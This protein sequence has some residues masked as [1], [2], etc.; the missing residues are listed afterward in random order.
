MQMQ[1]A[2]ASDYMS[3]QNNS[4]IGRQMQLLQSQLEY[5]QTEAGK[6]YS[7]WQCQM[8]GRP[9]CSQKAHSA[10]PL[11]AAAEQGYKTATAAAGQIN[12]KLSALRN[13]ESAMT[14]DFISVDDAN[15]GLLARLSALNAAAGHS[16]VLMTMQ[17]LLFLLFAMVECLPVI[18]RT[19]HIFGPQNT[20]EKILR[21]RELDNIR[22]AGGNNMQW[23]KLR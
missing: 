8:Y 23:T 9:F 3:L 13:E 18:F 15:T 19:V 7:Q 22:A 4:G 16:S 10:G 2:D 20:Y 11:A 21:M 5:E 14:Q 17:V 1:Q 12:P 6:F